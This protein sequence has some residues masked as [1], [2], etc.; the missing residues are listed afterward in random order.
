MK[1][2]HLTLC[3]L[4]GGVIRSKFNLFHITDLFFKN[5]FNNILLPT[6]RPSNWS[7]LFR[8]IY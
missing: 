4:L 8:I 3:D 1:M 7:V 2:L 6:P 5:H